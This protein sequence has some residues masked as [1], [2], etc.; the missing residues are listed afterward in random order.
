[1]LDS[2]DVCLALGEEFFG[3]A[4]KDNGLT[5]LSSGLKAQSYS[6]SVIIKRF[7]ANESTVSDFCIQC[8]QRHED[9]AQ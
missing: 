4:F 8:Q 5:T 7:E 6:Q 9:G 2:L 1:L 3:L